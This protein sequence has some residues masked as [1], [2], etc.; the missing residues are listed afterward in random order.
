MKIVPRIVTLLAVCMALVA[1]A[2]PPALSRVATHS[3][4]P[5]HAAVRAG[6][7]VT[8]LIDKDVVEIEAAGSGIEEVT[9]KIRRTAPGSVLV[10]FPV[11]SY[12]TSGDTGSQDMVSTAS[13]TVS[14]VGTRWHTVTIPTACA[15]RP[16]DVPDSDVGFTVQRSPDQAELARLMPV[17][18]AAAVPYPV[19]QAA[20]WIVTDNATYEELGVLEEGTDG[21]GGDRVINEPQA[22]LAMKL[23]SSAGIDITSRAIWNDRDEILEGLKAGPLK[24]W[25]ARKQPPQEPA[26]SPPEPQ[27]VAPGEMP[28]SPA[29]EPIA[30][31]SPEPGTRAGEHPSFSGLVVPDELPEAIAKVPPVYPDAARAAGVEGVVSVRV[32]VSTAGRVVGYHVDKSIP[33]LDNAAIAAV[34]QWKFKPALKNNM[35]VEAWVAVPVEFSPH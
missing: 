31:L 6:H 11:G 32:L 23:C 27:G 17:V 13:R 33:V 10:R 24:R 16:K 35:P 18:A 1:L 29:Q 5:A 21:A 4:R 3:R 8:D 34:K 9:V 7:D 19:R 12:F 28:I 22:A 14:L 2:A 15:N 26:A 25:L 30:P 20:V